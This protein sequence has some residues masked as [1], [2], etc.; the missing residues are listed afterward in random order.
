MEDP[1]QNDRS[2]EPGQQ[3]AAQPPEIKLADKLPPEARSFLAFYWNQSKFIVL[4]PR[5]FFSSMPVAGGYKDPMLFLA[6]SAGVNALFVGLMKFNPL[7][8]LGMLAASFIGVWLSGVIACF[9]SKSM[10]GQGALEGTVRVYSYSAVNLLYSWVPM[11]GFLGLVYTIVLNC[12]G[13]SQVHQ[14]GVVK[15]VAVVL[16]TTIGVGLVIGLLACSL[17]VRSFMPF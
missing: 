2:E 3:P 8:S 15:A 4:S 10:G 14:I 17:A 7:V 5:V 9:L 13:L 16:I 6:V 1:A 12:L 11:I